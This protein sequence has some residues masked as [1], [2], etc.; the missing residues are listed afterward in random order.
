ML[1]MFWDSQGPILERYQERG[2]IMSIA[3]CSEMLRD[4]LKPAIQ[5]KRRGQPSKGIVFV[6]DNASPYIALHC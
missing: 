1:T 6:H 3:R 5:S 2:V 4:K